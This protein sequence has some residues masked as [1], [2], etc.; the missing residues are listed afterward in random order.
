MWRVPLC[1]GVSVSV[2]VNCAMPGQVCAPCVLSFI[3]GGETGATGGRV[4]DREYVARGRSRQR[5]P[6]TAGVWVFRMAHLRG[7]WDEE[8][9]WLIHSGSGKR[10]WGQQQGPYFWVPW[11]HATAFSVSRLHNVVL[12]GGAR[13]QYPGRLPARRQV[14][15]QAGCRQH[16]P[17][18]HAWGGCQHRMLPRKQPRDGQGG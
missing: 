8:T 17:R 2:S 7:Q 18:G 5:C 3:V 1:T 6:G 10:R 13:A 11:G 16:V 15:V 12:F 14:W 9:Y 4:G